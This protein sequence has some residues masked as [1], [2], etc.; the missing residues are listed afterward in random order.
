MALYYTVGTY[1]VLVVA[2]SYL[3]SVH[4][5]IVLDIHFPPK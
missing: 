2:F 1:Q 4:C 5:F 3:V